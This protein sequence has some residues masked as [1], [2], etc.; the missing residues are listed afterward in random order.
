MYIYVVWH[1]SGMMQA[2]CFNILFVHVQ[3]AVISSVHNSIQNS[4]L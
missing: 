2:V 1:H 4:E 3:S